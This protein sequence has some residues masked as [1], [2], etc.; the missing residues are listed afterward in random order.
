MSLAADGQDGNGLH[1]DKLR[2]N[3][4]SCF[5]RLQKIDIN[6]RRVCLLFANL[7]YLSLWMFKDNVLNALSWLPLNF[8]IVWAKNLRNPRDRAPLSVKVDGRKR[9]P[10]TSPGSVLLSAAIWLVAR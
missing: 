7:G 9:F 1:L 2:L 10:N 8:T 6:G 5:Q 4:S 3:F